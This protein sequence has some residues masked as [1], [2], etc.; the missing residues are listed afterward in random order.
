MGYQN[1]FGHR[2]KIIFASL[3][4][5]TLGPYTLAFV[6]VVVSRGGIVKPTEIGYL[7]T[8]ETS[9]GS[10]LAK[11]DRLWI[12]GL[13]S[14]I[15]AKTSFV[16]PS[17]TAITAVNSP[18]FTVN[19]GFTGDAVSAYI[20][21]NYNPSTSAVKYTQNSASAFV[22][23]RTSDQSPRS[24][25]GSVGLTPL[26][27]IQMYIRANSDV[28]IG[29]INANGS[30][31]GVNSNGTGFYSLVRTGSNSSSIYKNGLLLSSGTKASVLPPYNLYL[32]CINVA[33][34]GADFGNRQI[35]VSGTSDG[36]VNQAN[37]YHYIQVL[38][39]SIGWAI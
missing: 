5:P 23:S 28:I 38:G 22:Y 35:S 8:F 36:T 10:E 33:G 7:N 18:T 1:T 29:D 30:T 39:T 16:N 9:M 31:F 20:D 2:Q 14:P 13:F 25:F 34:T 21:T 17:S 37:F 6:A 4:G 12:H 27:L 24:D 15:A 19:R 26:S 32:F 3:N 11:F